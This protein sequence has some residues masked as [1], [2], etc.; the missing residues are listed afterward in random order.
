MK[1]RSY[2]IS[3]FILTILLGMLVLF[4]VLPPSLEIH[5]FFDA[6]SLFAIFIPMICFYIIVFPD[7][8]QVSD[9]FLNKYKM[10]W[11][12]EIS[13]LMGVYWCFFGF[14]SSWHGFLSG[15]M[16]ELLNQGVSTLKFLTANLSVAFI[17]VLYSFL[18]ALSF[19]ILSFFV[20]GSPID[21]RDKRKRYFV[22]IIS[23][24]MTILVFHFTYNVA[25]DTKGKGFFDSVFYIYSILG[26]SS[27]P[28]ISMFVGVLLFFVVQRNTSLLNLF[29]N[30]VSDTDESEDQTVSQ[31]YAIS[32]TKK[33]ISGIYMIAV[34]SIP[35]MLFG[36]LVMYIENSNE[37]FM[38][39][40]STSKVMMF[41]VLLT[42]VFSILEAKF[43]YK[44]YRSEKRI[45]RDGMFLPKYM[46]LPTILYF[47]IVVFVFVLSTVLF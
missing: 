7:V 18:I 29:L 46:A 25:I 5:F 47:L 14:T 12:M 32:K 45:I 31:L 22:N 23:L 11:I 38:L 19:F 6:I 27:I 8:N 16:E 15:S 20:K 34:V 4:S 1:S 24:L 30:L 44:L 35:M 3:G 42:I 2:L 17:T 41:C 36:T 10:L 28:L 9:K 13:I 39:L 37:L 43:N 21:K 33:I 26:Y 40:F